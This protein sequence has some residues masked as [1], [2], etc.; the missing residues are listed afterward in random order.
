MT[1]DHFVQGDELNTKIRDYRD[2]AF[3]LI[4]IRA[5]LEMCVAVWRNLTTVSYGISQPGQ[6]SGP[7]HF[8]TPMNLSNIILK[9]N[10]NDCYF[11]L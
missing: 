8:W 10:N 7:N 5:S 1:G 3:W 4:D 9:K 6:K 11:L 2:T